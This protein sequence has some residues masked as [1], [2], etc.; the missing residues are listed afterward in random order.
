MVEKTNHIRIYCKTKIVE[1]KKNEDGSSV[2][3][4]E[5]IPDPKRYQLITRNGDEG[6]W[7]ETNH[8]PAGS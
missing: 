6:Y 2:Y 7:S 5:S 8:E 4:I 3:T 1:T